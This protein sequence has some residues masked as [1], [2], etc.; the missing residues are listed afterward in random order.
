MTYEVPTRPIRRSRR[1]ILIPPLIAVAVVAAALIAGPPRVPEPSVSPSP[2]ASPTASVLSADLT[3]CNELRAYPCRDVIR[4][5]QLALDRTYSPIASATAW[6]SLI[7][8]NDSDCPRGFLDRARP[9]GSVVFTFVDGSVAWV[10]VLWLDVS[11][12]RFEDGTERMDAY[13][14]R[15]FGPKT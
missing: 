5:A 4:V 7:C 8:G 14:V 10:N 9:A 12:R 1:P 11:S 6:R 3:A 13:I 2:A 15:A